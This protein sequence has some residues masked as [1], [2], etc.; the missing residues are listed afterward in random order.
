MS[1]LPHPV[2]ALGAGTSPPFSET[3]SVLFDGVDDY[4]SVGN[5]SDFAGSNQS[6]SVAVW[7]KTSASGSTMDIVSRYGATVAERDFTLQMNSSNQIS[8][9]LLTVAHGGKTAT[10]ASAYNDGRWHLAIATY[11][12]ASTTLT[13]DIDGGAERVS[14]TSVPTRRNVTVNLEIG[15]RSNTAALFWNGGLDEIAYYSDA[16]SAAE[17][18]AIYNGGTPI[19]LNAHAAT[20][21]SLVSWWRMGDAQFDSTDSSLA[22]ARIYDIISSNNGTP[23]NMTAGDIVLDVPPSPA[24]WANAYSG[25]FDSA[26]DYLEG[27]TSL[28]NFD[29][30]D[31]WSVN[32]WCRT[33]VV[34]QHAF[35]VFKLD[36]GGSNRGWFCG[37]YQDK[38]IAGI[39]HDLAAGWQLERG[40]RPGTAYV[41]TGSWHMLTFTYDGSETVGGIKLYVDGIE[42][43]SYVDYATSIQSP[44]TSTGPLSVGNEFVAKGTTF[45]GG[46][47]DEV[48]VY[49]VALSAGTITTLFNLQAYAQGKAYDITGVSGIQSYWQLGDHAGD[50]FAAGGTL[51]DGVGSNDLTAYNTVAGNKSTDNASEFTE[52]VSLDFDGVDDIAIAAS[53]PA[54]DY[55]SAFSLSAWIK[56]TASNFGNIGGKQHN[57][58]NYRGWGLFIN[59]SSAGAF[60]IQMYSTLGSNQLNVQTTNNGWNDG[61]WHHVVMTHDGSGTAAGLRI[62]VDGTSEAL[63]V[64]SNSLSG[65]ILTSDGFSLGTRGTTS[66]SAYLE[67]RLDEVALYSTELSSGDV[68]AIFNG[69]TP[70]DLS[71]LPSWTNIHTW[72]RLGEGQAD[73]AGVTSKISAAG[74]TANYLTCS[75]M[76]DDDIVVDSP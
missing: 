49:N 42:V 34:G 8:I 21:A 74:T 63:T 13:I 67:G 76:T 28:L 4:L 12:Y 22:Y 50:S 41:S 1:P 19:D 61:A 59:P 33:S 45:F 43:G 37:L 23:V 55:T 75:N 73:K 65:T 17:C 44:T 7:F 71:A 5:T 3:K 53:P 62:Y 46:Y 27:S 14:N 39:V 18:V 9:Y 32:L 40:A 69:G 31:P 57:A 68:T 35:L 10:T 51:H 58:P 60:G 6:F 26:D 25:F 29:S 15:R 24:L 16:L 56:T 72:W 64:N 38:P 70:N 20:S 30:T 2:A 11:D 47:L 36:T 54:Y 52:I 48:S 66:P